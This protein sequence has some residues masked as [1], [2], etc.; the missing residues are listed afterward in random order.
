[1]KKSVL[2]NLKPYQ[3]SKKDTRK[4]NGGSPL[5]DCIATAQRDGN[6]WLIDTCYEVLGD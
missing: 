5:S 4:I 6:E 3:I 2:E 1:M